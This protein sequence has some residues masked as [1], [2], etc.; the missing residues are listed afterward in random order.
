[1]KFKTKLSLAAVG[2]ALLAIGVMLFKKP[3]ATSYSSVHV[4]TVSDSAADKVS[5]PR[6]LNEP[7]QVQR[8]QTALADQGLQII[9]PD[10]PSYQGTL[11]QLGAYYRAIFEDLTRK[12][13]VPNADFEKIIELLSTARLS[14]MMYEATNAKVVESNADKVSLVIPPYAAEG[15]HLKEYVYKNLPRQLATP[16]FENMLVSAFTS[17]GTYPQRLEFQKDV[18]DGEK[19]FYKV[20]RS[21]QAR[22]GVPLT[23]ISTLSFSELGDWAPFAGFFPKS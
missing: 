13:K 4:T 11:R 12:Q 15:M 5:K 16:E 7:A 21:S 17:F 22:G 8:P 3:R 18:L 20:V 6:E 10:N 2:T 9:D 23:T 14:Q 1:M 19:Q